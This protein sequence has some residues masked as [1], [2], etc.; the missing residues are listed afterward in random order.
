M[1]EIQ[2]GNL[3]LFAPRTRGASAPALSQPL[4]KIPALVRVAHQGKGGAVG[5]ARFGVPREPAQ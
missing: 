1:R 3:R 5:I 4:L 2:R